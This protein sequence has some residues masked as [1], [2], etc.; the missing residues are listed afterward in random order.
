M[1]LFQYWDTKEPPEDVAQ[2]L[3]DFGRHNPDLDQLVFHADT[4]A[5]FIS[6]H[7]GPRELAAFRACAVPAMQADLVR[8]CALDVFGGVY[9][10]ADHQSLQPLS[11][12]IADIPG[13]LVF[14]WLGLLNNAVLMF[15]TPR[16]PFIRACLDLAVDNVEE[17][18]FTSAFTATGPGVFNAVRA[19]IDPHLADGIAAAL[20]DPGHDWEFSKLLELA[21]ARL[22]VTPELLAS[23]QAI[24]FMNPISASLHI[25]LSQ[26][27][28]K[29]TDRHW[30]RWTGSIYTTP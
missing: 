12:L 19:M 13:S 6:D 22:T 17:R 1:R 23:Y 3:R 14:E 4:A 20:N 2:W 5:E 24:T 25:G 8:L 28:Y 15:R 10:D 27:A 16:D 9:I 21:R 18:R 11:S 26:P 7:Y 29:T 30:A